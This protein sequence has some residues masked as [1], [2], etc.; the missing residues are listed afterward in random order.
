[1]TYAAFPVAGVPGVPVFLGTTIG[2]PHIERRPRY[3]AI[4]NDYAGG[5]VELDSMYMGQDGLVQGTYNR[6][7]LGVWN[8]M[9]RYASTNL[10]LDSTPVGA[11][12]EGYRGTFMMQEGAGFTLWLKF[13]FF[14]KASMNPGGSDNMINGYRFLHAWLITD[15]SNPGVDALDLVLAWHALGVFLPTANG[16]VFKLYDYDM[17]TLP[18]PD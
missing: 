3:R 10:N 7:H 12:G 14:F 9:E 11:D 1:M 18:P 6:M 16:G 15:T 13:P 17:T 5:V 2:K 8:A 4:H